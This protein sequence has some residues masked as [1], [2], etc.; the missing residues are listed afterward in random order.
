[1]IKMEGNTMNNEAKLRPF[2]IARIL[3]EYTDC[4]HSLTASQI[5]NILENEYGIK[6]YRTTIGAD[7]EILHNL[8]VNI[9]LTKSSQ[10]QYNIFNRHFDDIELKLLIDAVESSKFISKDQS[11][12]IVRK[13]SALASKN[14]SN[15]LKRNI[16][17]ER[18]IKSC[19][20]HVIEIAD[21]INEAKNLK[22]Q[23][24]FQ[25]FQYNVRK[26]L[27][28]RHNGYWYKLSPYRLI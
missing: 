10:N 17:V 16:S 20:E 13:I 9:R 15:K 19:N 11:T 26:E 23:I 22:K 1:M 4:E 6:S 5:A 8:G 21:A 14:V 25:Y 18:R 28:P 7:I 3:Y 12:E 24:S 27:V 2:Y